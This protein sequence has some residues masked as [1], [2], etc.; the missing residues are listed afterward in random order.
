[1]FSLYGSVT[2]TFVSYKQEKTSRAPVSSE[3]SGFTRYNHF[4]QSLSYTSLVCLL[5]PCNTLQRGNSSAAEVLCVSVSP[6][7]CGP[8]EHDRD[9]LADMLTMMRGWTLLILE[10][11][12]QG[13]N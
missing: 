1:M 3:T 6:S 7:V 11:K 8:R 10:V 13:H 9:Y 5:S 12:S 2:K 4:K